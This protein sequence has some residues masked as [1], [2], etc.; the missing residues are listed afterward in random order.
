MDKTKIKIVGIGEGGARAVVKMIAMG[1]GKKENVEFVSVGKDENILLTSATRNNIFLNQDPPT[2]YK[3]ISM[4]LRDAKIVI[5][6]AG[7]GGSAAV[8]ALPRIISFSKNINAATVAFVNKPFVLEN[9][10]RKKNAEYC[11]NCLREVD[12][13]F[14]L[15]AEKFFLFR[16]YQ[17]E[18]SIGE[19]FEVANEIFSMGARIFLDMSSDKNSPLKLGKAAFGYGLGA[20]V[21]EAVKNAVKFPAFEPEEFNHSKKIFV[22]HTGGE[23]KQAKNFIREIIQPDAKLFWQVD[24]SHGEKILASIIFKGEGIREKGEGIRF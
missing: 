6:V 20:T 5:L 16:L 7:I 4:A 14:I 13:S 24:N 3:S 11:L 8:K 2:I 23:D 21:L 10:E 9:M 12:T 19:L 22:R 1:L 17:R 15:P 18:I